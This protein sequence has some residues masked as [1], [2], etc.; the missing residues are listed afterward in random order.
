MLATAAVCMLVGLA[1]AGPPDFAAERA[2]MVARLRKQRITNERVLNAMARVPR[3]MF[4]DPAQR[5]RAYD[6]TEIPLGSSQVMCRPFVAA[7]M[8]QA[9]NPRSD[10]KILEVGTGSGY[11]AAVLA[12]MT[13]QVYSVDARTNISR[14]AQAHLQSLDY[15]SINCRIANACQGWPQHAPFDGIIVTCAADAVP[16]AL[17]SQLREGGKLVIPIGHGPEQTLNCM[18]KSAGKLRSETI[19]TIR[20]SPMICQRRR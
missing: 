16:E 11:L 13:P 4:M 3:H 15:T 17:V 20:V 6:D 8:A 14:E 10:A 1:Y 5:M 19:A 9:L 18:R 7:L 12:E 2:A